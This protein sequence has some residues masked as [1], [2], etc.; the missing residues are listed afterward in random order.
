[1]ALR[2]TEP[3]TDTDADSYRDTGETCLGGGMHCP[4]AFSLQVQHGD[5]LFFSEM[6]ENVSELVVN[7][8]TSSPAIIRDTEFCE[9]CT[10]GCLLFV[11]SR[12]VI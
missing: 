6:E 4:S 9:H 1:M 8:L 11:C 5:L 7:A 10:Y 3:D 2:I 12:E